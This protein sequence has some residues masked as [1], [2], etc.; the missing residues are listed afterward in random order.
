MSC[1]STA[2]TSALTSFARFSYPNLSD[3]QIQS[4]FH[5]LKR[6]AP[7]DTFTK[8]EYLAF[9]NS[10]MMAVRNSDLSE[11]N[12]ESLTQRLED[13]TVRLDGLTPDNVYAAKNILAE[14]AIA[15]R[16]LDSVSA[17]V[18]SSLGR[19]TEFIRFKLNRWREASED[20]YED[21]ENFAEEFRYDLT[22]GVPQDEATLRSLRKLGYEHFLTQPYPVFVYGTLR[23]GQGNFPIFG[24]HYYDAEGG[25][26]SGISIYG[27]ERAFPYAKEDEDNS[28]TAFVK[29]DIIWIDQTSFGSEVR[30]SLDSLE[31]FSSD[32]P[33][34]SHYERKLKV[35][36]F[37]DAEG[38]QVEQPVWMYVASGRYRSQLSKQDIIEGGDWVEARKKYLDSP[39]GRKD[40]RF[41][42]SE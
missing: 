11:R 27:A 28:S 5:G 6:S 1:R 41:Y 7:N 29:G 25:E 19:S 22:P 31:G 10:Q 40:R 35:A 21:V 26:V 4:L 9:V 23:R 37:K 17:K 16:A 24:G 3:S 8:E 13:S 20:S 14:A 38:K 2:F 12:I 39:M 32:F 36:T 42:Y 18:G 33:S 15:D 34:D 30:Y